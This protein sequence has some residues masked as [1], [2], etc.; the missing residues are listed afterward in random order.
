MVHRSD[1]P[2]TPLDVV[3]QSLRCLPA[4]QG[5]TIAESAVKK[6]HI[7]LAELRA[8]FPAA[9][10]KALLNLVGRIRPQSGSIIETIARYLLEEA[11]LTVE[12][13]VHIPGMGHL[14][15]LVDGL[16]GIEAD[17]YAHHSS[18][19]A[20]REDRR[21]WNVTVIGGVPTLRVTFEM[22]VR[23][24]AEFVRMVELALATYRR[25]R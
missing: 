18:R 4:L 16:L 3:C 10:E 22:L 13:Q 14:D 20:Y 8:R 12:L 23:D 1:L 24:P 21:R 9:R 5:L 19:E 11:G 25:A 7:Q 15:L 17:G 6:G 2:L